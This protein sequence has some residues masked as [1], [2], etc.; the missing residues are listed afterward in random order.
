MLKVHISILN[1]GI[2]K[3]NVMR[4]DKK[5]MRYIAGL[6]CMVLLVT[7]IF[8]QV[9]VNASA[10]Q[11]VGDTEKVENE[12]TGN[13]EEEQQ[14][15][16]PSA[17]PEQ[18]AGELISDAPAVYPL[19]NDAADVNDE[20]LVSEYMYED[21]DMLVKAE[22]TNPSAIP[23]GA[24]LQIRS[25]VAEDETQKDRYYNISGFLTQK[26][27]EEQFVLDGFLAY[28]LYFLYNGQEI[29]PADGE[30]NVSITYKNEIVPDAYKNSQQD[31][32]EVK[33]YQLQKDASQEETILLADSVLL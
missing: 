18:T 26:A 21:D 6:L 17:N 15:K 32:K 8:P 13:A 24:E 33:L 7:T 1:K 23:Q 2:G 30:V 27:K 14:E 20:P 11:G 16:E 3:G 9:T 4:A 25:I 10:E 19:N 12:D 22:L 29:V 5:I 28:E 31:G